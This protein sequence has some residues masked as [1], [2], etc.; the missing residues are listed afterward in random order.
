LI[1]FDNIVLIFFAT[2]DSV[3]VL[4][5]TVLKSTVQWSFSNTS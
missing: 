1:G 4:L 2:F 3:L 5:I